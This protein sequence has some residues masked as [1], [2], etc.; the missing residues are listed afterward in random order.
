[1]IIN[2]EWVKDYINRNG[3]KIVIPKECI[4]IKTGSFNDLS[5]T[6]SKQLQDGIELFFE[7]G[8]QLEKIEQ[9]AFNVNILNVVQLPP[10][11]KILEQYAFA[12]YPYS[13]DLP[14]E[15]S[16]QICDCDFVFFNKKNVTLPKNPEQIIMFELI[17]LSSV[18]IP[19]D[20][21][22]TNF[23]IVNG[24]DKI[25]LPNSFDL[26]STNSKRYRSVRL[27]GNNAIILYTNLDS[28]VGFEIMDLTTNSI[29]YSG[30]T[31]RY[32]NDLYQNCVFEFDDIFNI[33]F[34]VL[35]DD[36]LITLETDFTR[37]R[38]FFITKRLH[39]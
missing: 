36:D 32:G 6:V 31:C 8:S 21:K 10:S 17:H 24:A 38:G 34:D 18:T 4:C 23:I 14:E 35:N 11:I 3:T 33:D 19:P 27:N 13:I 15:S 12:G 9:F 20:S 39:T 1:M 26:I 16:I 22:L 29:T 37:N 2:D 5:N 7:E 28:S 25:T 30:K